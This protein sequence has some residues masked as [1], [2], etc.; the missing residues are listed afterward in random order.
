MSEKKAE[1]Q[2]LERDLDVQ[3]EMMEGEYQEIVIVGGGIAGLATS[4]ALRR[5]GLQPL[6]LE[7]SKELRVTGAAISLAPNAWRALETLGVAHKLTP[8]YAPLNTMVFTDLSSGKTISTN[9]LLNISDDLSLRSVHR[10]AL[11]EALAEELPPTAIRFGSKL[12]SI[13]NLP[14]SSL[15]ALHLEDGTVIKTKVLI[16]CDGVRSVVAQ[17]LGLLQPVHSGRSAV[18][19]IAVFPNGHG[20][21]KNEV[22]QVLGE[23]TR[24]GFIPLNDKEVYWFM[25]YKSHLDQDADLWKHPELIRD[26]VLQRI[27]KAFPA[28]FV[29]V[30]R[31]SDLET[32]SLAPLIF[33]YP[34]DLFFG[35]VSKG[36]VTV[37][38][39]AMHPMTP[40]LGQG[41]CSAL[42][43]AVVLAR[44]LG[45][46]LQKDGRTEFDEKSAEEALKKYAKERRMRTAGLI[47]GSL[48]SGWLQGETG[49][50]VKMIRNTILYRYLFSKLP[51][52]VD[53]DCG[54]LPVIG[55]HS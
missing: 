16:G 11:L 3:R 37:A 47:T 4:I 50:L 53:Y 31:K 41:G 10:K 43:D 26:T 7:G 51:Q 46:T 48:L 32:T 24:S 6:V 1:K 34:W 52:V 30:V 35:H 36:N 49:W 20:F 8:F 54:K 5:M 2:T 27:E 19:A 15:L 29:E 45:E 33:R 42:E 14:D 12:S 28:K 25:T 38:G 17:W 18:R 23:G 39:D 55:S 21:T 44:N 40:D 13:K 9:S 22:Y